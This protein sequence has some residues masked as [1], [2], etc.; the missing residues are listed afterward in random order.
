MFFALDDLN[1]AC[2]G[3]TYVANYSCKKFLYDL[4]LSYN[5]S[6]TDGQMDG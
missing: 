2:P 1:F 6:V 3:L 5:T 4:K